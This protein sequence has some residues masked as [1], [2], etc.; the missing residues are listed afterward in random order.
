[1]RNYLL[2]GSF[3]VLLLVFVAAKNEINRGVRDEREKEENEKAEQ[4]QP[5]L[6]STSG[7]SH[8]GV[9]MS[10]PTLTSHARPPPSLQLLSASPVGQ[11][12]AVWRPISDCPARRP[13]VVEHV[14]EDTGA[15]G[16]MGL[17]EAL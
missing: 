4:H 1:L 2:S 14:E 11:M 9:Q 8:A 15:C 13:L 6:T 5:G 16:T 3:V 7:R 12:L 17:D 10:W